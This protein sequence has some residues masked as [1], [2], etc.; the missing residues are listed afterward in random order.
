[1]SGIKSGNCTR[2]RNSRLMKLTYLGHCN[3]TSIFQK[4]QP[5]DDA[6]T[7]LTVGRKSTY[8]SLYRWRIFLLYLS[9]HIFHPIY[10][11]DIILSLTRRLYV[12]IS[13]CQWSVDYDERWRR[14]T[15]SFGI[16]PFSFVASKKNQFKL[17]TSKHFQQQQRCDFS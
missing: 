8:L 13:D 15:I 3:A 4:H 9:T 17:K 6:T 16:F 14:K 11:H 2:L 1:M 7:S 10:L 5:D 12:E